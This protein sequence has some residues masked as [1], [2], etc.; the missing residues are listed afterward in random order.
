MNLNRSRAQVGQSM[1]PLVH[2]ARLARQTR[3]RRASWIL[4][5]LIVL[6]SA[7]PTPA[8]DLSSPEFSSREA[9]AQRL[10]SVEAE[11]RDSAVASNP[12]ARDL[13]LQLEAAGALPPVRAAGERRHGSLSIACSVRS[14]R[15]IPNRRSIGPLL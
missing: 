8:K 13:L 4:F 7:T 9:I 2:S 3:L 6:A 5:A 14:D 11:L 1:K 15:R 10:A 12:A